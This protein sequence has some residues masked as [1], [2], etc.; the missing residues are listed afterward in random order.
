MPLVSA[1]RNN[2]VYYVRISI[3][4]HLV[5]HINEHIDKYRQQTTLTTKIKTMQCSLGETF[6]KT[7]YLIFLSYYTLIGIK[8]SPSGTRWS[9]NYQGCLIKNLL[10]RILS[11]EVIK[12]ERKLKAKVIYNY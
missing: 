6:N 11:T 8:H 3:D 9:S 2:S 4:K 1:I 10:N 12:K 5:L 7:L